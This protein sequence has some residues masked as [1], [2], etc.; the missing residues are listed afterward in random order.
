MG[1]GWEACGGRAGGHE[2]AEGICRLAKGAAIV[3]FDVTYI[4]KQQRV[5]GRMRIDSTGVECSL[6]AGTRATI[7]GVKFSESP[8]TI[9]G[10]PR[11]RWERSPRSAFWGW[12]QER[13]SLC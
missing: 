11:L 7:R 1:G 3:E 2:R 10:G 4:A 9:R 8:S 12:L 5:G 6:D 13:R